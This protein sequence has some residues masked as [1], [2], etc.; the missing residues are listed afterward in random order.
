LTLRRLLAHGVIWLSLA[1]FMDFFTSGVMI[2]I[3]G[4]EVEGNLIVR[5]MFENPNVTTIG[6]AIEQ[7]YVWLGLIIF[8]LLCLQLL[9]QGKRINNR[10][11]RE[12][13]QILCTV[14]VV[15]VWFFAVLRLYS[16]AVG[17]LVQI[18]APYGM[19]A[20]A[21]VVM[22]GSAAIFVAV[23]VDIWLSGR[24]KQSP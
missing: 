23:A 11:L 24:R 13:V 5:T 3:R 17:N 21:I 16:G 22:F 9:K 4:A 15:L 6:A 20:Q 2:K 12:L 14:G 7:Q 8:G 19:G 1:V 10:R 18:V